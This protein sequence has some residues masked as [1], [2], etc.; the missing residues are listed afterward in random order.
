MEFRRTQKPQTKSDR[1]S[2]ASSD[3]RGRPSRNVGKSIDHRH[4]E[5]KVVHAELPAA[6]QPTRKIE[7]LPVHPRIIGNLLKKG[8]T[9]PTEIQDKAFE[10]LAQGRDFLGLAK[11]GTGKTAA[12]LV[13]LIEKL[14]TKAESGKLLVISPTRELAVQIENE[15]DSICKNLKLVSICLIGGTPIQTDILKLKCDVHAVI[16]TPGRIADL[17]Q[18]GKLH[19]REFSILV[20]DEFDRLLDMGFAHDVMKLAESME[21]RKQT[22]LFSA[23]EDKTQKSLMARLLKDEATVKLVSENSPADLIDQEIVKIKPGQNKIDVLVDMLKDKDFEKVLVFAETKHI[24]KRLTGKLKMTGIKADEIHGN[25]TQAQ[26]MRA[27]DA[28]KF[29]KIQ[30]LVATDVAARGLDI[31]NVSHVINFQEPKNLES[32]IH[33]IGRTGRAGNKG[34]AYTFVG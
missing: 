10:P 25:K 12:F 2:H 23:T 28:F 15:F 27:L 13:P 29:K 34:K 22:I 3:R 21:N 8:Y 20:L 19:L 7:E 5:K 1:P 33:R 30:V 4:F 26:R 31:Q 18:Q 14:Y 9:Y 32:Y 6:Y 11:T 24:V 17:V 16:G